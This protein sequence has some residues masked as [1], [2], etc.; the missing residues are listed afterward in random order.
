M[1][2][3]ME[4]YLVVKSMGYRNMVV[5]YFQDSGTLRQEVYFKFQV[6]LGYGQSTQPARV[7]QQVRGGAGN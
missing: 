7:T 2:F 1:K 3:Q 5:M 4:F 6:N